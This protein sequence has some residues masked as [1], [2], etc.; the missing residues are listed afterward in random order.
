MAGVHEKNVQQAVR[1]VVEEGDPAGH[2]FDQ[3][4]SGGSVSCGEQNQYPWEDRTS[5][6]GPG[7]GAGVWAS[8]AEHTKQCKRAGFGES[9]RRQFESLSQVL[10]IRPREIRFPEQASPS[11]G[12]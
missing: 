11:G 1:Y 6:R 5:K 12:L 10:W 3:I 4:F 9:R 2:G 8:K 7:P